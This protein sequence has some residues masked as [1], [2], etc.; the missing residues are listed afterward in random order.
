MQVRDS[1]YTGIHLFTYPVYYPLA[2]TSVRWFTRIK[3]PGTVDSP[4]IFYRIQPQWKLLSH[5]YISLLITVTKIL[6][7]FRTW[8]SPWIWPSL[9]TWLPYLPIPNWNHS[10]YITK[11]VKSILMVSLRLTTLFRSLGAYTSINS[12]VIPGKY[13]APV[14]CISSKIVTTINTVRPNAIVYHFTIINESNYTE[15]SHIYRLCSQTTNTCPYSYG[16]E[17][18]QSSHFTRY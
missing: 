9:V 4:R 15:G 12:H 1:F 16:N 7:F 11:Y 10:T 3:P 2:T 18:K 17:Q 6:L 13:V 8:V 14:F 5:A